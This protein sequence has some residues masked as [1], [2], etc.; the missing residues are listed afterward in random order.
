VAVKTIDLGKSEDVLTLGR[1][2][3]KKD[4]KLPP[5]GILA[6]LVQG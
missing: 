6:V 4:L 2:S 3:A 5:E 1:H